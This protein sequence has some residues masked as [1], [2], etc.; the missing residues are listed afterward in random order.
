MFQRPRKSSP[1]PELSPRADASGAGGRTSR[2][3]SEWR[4]DSKRVGRAYHA[5]C[6]ADRRDRGRLYLSF[7]DAL[8]REERAAQQLEHVT[9]TLGTAD[10]VA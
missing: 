7:L 6:A 2:L 8:T 5:W 10:P 1:V 9:S 3:L 4:E